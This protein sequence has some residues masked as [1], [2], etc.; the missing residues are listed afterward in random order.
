MSKKDGK[1]PKGNKVNGISRKDFAFSIVAVLLIG[2]IIGFSFFTP[3][4]SRRVSFEGRTIEMLIPAVDAEGNGVAGRLITNVRSGTGRV[5][6][7]VDGPLTGFDTQISARNAAYQA[8]K[9][10]GV[11]MNDYDVNYV[12]E[13]DANIIDG[14]SAGAA[15]A[16]STSLALLDK[17]LHYSI[18]ATGTIESDGTIGSVGKVATKSN[19]VKESGISVFFVPEGQ[20][21]ESRITK[22]TDCRAAGSFK[23]C[24]TRYI[25]ESI[26]IDRDGLQ[27]VEVGTLAEAMNYLVNGT[28]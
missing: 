4:T 25:E 15:M 24:R 3:S 6:I 22:Q 8:A 28:I 14:P 26:A 5:T 12:F 16:I 18:S 1:F 20:G 23:V 27:V 17:E 7:D 10:A 11:D 21:T 19:V 2:V 9:Y 13:A